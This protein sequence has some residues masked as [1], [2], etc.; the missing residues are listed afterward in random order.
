MSEPK[1]HIFDDFSSAARIDNFRV[2]ADKRLEQRGGTALIHTFDA[3]LR[4]ALTVGVSDGEEI[5]AVSGS[6]LWRLTE[7]DGVFTAVSLGT[8]E[9][10]AFADENE[11]VE[12]FLFTGKLYILGG[13]NY[14]C[15]DGSAL[16]VVEGY[17]PLWR[18]YSGATGGSQA[19]ERRNLLTNRVR[20]RFCPDGES[21]EFKLYGKAVSVESVWVSGTKLETDMYSVRFSENTGYVEMALIYSE[22]S[23]D[24]IEIYYTL[25][26]DGRRS[27]V[28]SCPHAAVYGGDTDTRVFLYGG[29]N[30]SVIY[31]TDL[32]GA[33]DTPAISAEYFPIGADITVGDGNLR[34]TGAVRQ[35]DR[36][37]IFTEEGAFYTYPYDAGTVNGIQRFTYPIL[38]LNSDVGAT[39]EGGA[40]LL[41]N[42]PYALNPNGLYRFKSTSV[43]DERLAVRVEAPDFIGLDREFIDACGLYVNKLRGELWCYHNGVMA[44]YNARLDVWYRF[45]GVDPHF[46]F[47][48]QSEAA[49]GEGNSLYRFGE[50]LYDDEGTPFTA[51]FVSL[52]LDLGAAFERKTIY[53]FGVSLERRPSAS[54]ICSLSTDLGGEW[55]HTFTLD[56]GDGSTPVVCHSHARLGRVAYAVFSLEAPGGCDASVGVREVMVEVR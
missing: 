20:E 36:L 11:R 45:T 30:R 46:M 5:Y 3:P 17:I 1:K 19:Y 43:R 12:M 39:R 33:E 44:I 32:V 24:I 15:W 16:S 6:K 41:E 37:A 54:V 34:V 4:G 40:V 56:E 13:G 2:T 9:D 10:A 21:R 22:N 25:V 14:Y 53:G 42:E 29:S 52:P 47:T 8:L 49:F 38:P 28:T 50:G 35:F 48:Y 27:D 18:R 26:D 55:S 23:N 51:Q 7:A 31:P